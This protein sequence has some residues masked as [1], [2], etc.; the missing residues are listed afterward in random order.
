MKHLYE[1]LR[2]CAKEEEVKAEFCK[3]FKMKIF[4]LRGIDHY[5]EHVLFEFKYDRNF[6]NAENVARVLAQTMYY[7]RLLK[8]GAGLTR[9]PLPPVICVVDKNEAFFAETKAYAKFYAAKGDR[10][11]WDRAPSTPCPK[12]VGDIL[13]AFLKQ[14][15]LLTPNG[16]RDTGGSQFT[17]T[18][19]SDAT[20]CV[21][22]AVS[23]VSGEQIRLLKIPYIYDLS[24]P[25][26][27]EQFVKLCHEHLT[28][29][30]TFLELLGKK[31][32]T[33]EN[34]LDVFDYWD[35]LFGAYV[36]NGRKSSE[37]FFA[38]IEQGKSI[39]AQDGQVLFSVSGAE[40]YIPKSIQPEKYQ[41]FWQNY[42]KVPPPAMT[43]IRQKADRITEDFRRRFTGEFYTPVE[44]AAKGLDYL[45]RTIGREWWKSGEYRFWDMAA[46]T[47]NL[48]F[49]L[50]SS[51]LPYCY[52]STLDKEDADYCR[53]IFPAATC[54]QYDYLADDIPALAG[55]M[56]FGQTRKMPPNLVADLANPNIKWIIFINPPFA[57]ANTVGG[58]TG[59]KSK[60]TV[61]KTTIREWM[62]E[63]DYGEASRELFTQFLFRISK[64][65]KDKQA[66]LCMFSKL[67]YINS[68]NDQKI[69]DGFFQYQYERGFIFPIKC[70]YGATGNFPVGF[71]VW[72]LAEKKHLSMQSIT[73]DVF[74]REVEKIGTKVFPSVERMA[75]LN[76]W[77]PRPKW[78]GKSIM[79]TFVSAF[80]LKTDNKD[81]RNHV[82]PGFICSVSSN[83]DDFQHTNS[84]FILS[85]PYANAGAF[86]VT[87]E[88]FEKAM[89]LHAVKKI[90]KATWTNDRDAFY[91]PTTKWES[92]KERKEHKDFA[93][94]AFF[95]AET[96]DAATGLP[97]EFVT[98]CVV[99]SA[100]ADSNC[101][102]SL[103]NVEYQ[104]RTW[105]I[106]NNLYPFLL[107]E[108]RR[109]PCAHGDIA[110][111]LATANED[112]F[113]AKWLAG[114]AL[115]P[116]ACA[117]LDAARRLYREFY[118]NITH[119]PWMDWKIETWDVGY[120]QLRNAMKDLR[121]SAPPREEN[122]LREKHDALRAKLL[123][124][125]YSL[126]FLNPDVEYFR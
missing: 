77:C 25:A 59:K 106:Q 24:N 23:R 73:L 122:S 44:F 58:E 81:K 104:G 60:D 99:W 86:S 7:A 114:K 20:S 13:A 118:A 72:N 12:L 95:A 38:D 57:T 120:Y 17:A 88:N 65:F 29:Q 107:E 92:R 27:E 91:A 111:Q 89:V 43:R 80:N 102:V 48:E 15:D 98:D 16:V 1:S 42:E 112:R 97:S 110:T 22:P 56:T 51:A 70:F 28:H 113:L 31:T 52:I 69:R 6:K 76:K 46:G 116:E 41:H 71:L 83:G 19:A 103:R 10:Y 64:E 93:N 100:F 11:D 63:E 53:K 18:A 4:A 117:V 67:K 124:Q 21:P 49:E 45:E 84:V 78:D 125:I 115:S 108:V 66:H 85:A 5:T 54:F 109:W 87:P 26:E 119:T 96:T 34:F 74:N 90:P 121:D 50:P 32:I 39:V 33:E 101:A 2:P 47:G 75:M 8:F 55:Q 82:A 3:F 36:R 105:Q 123:P 40:G 94:S 126:G 62:Y 14:A 68:N 61:S 30:T 35:G 37:Y 9:Y 79:P